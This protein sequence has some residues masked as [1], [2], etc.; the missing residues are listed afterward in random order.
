[1]QYQKRFY[2]LV[3]LLLIF[4]LSA[5]SLYAQDEPQP[6]DITL[7][8]VR[9]GVLA[10]RPKPQ[11]LAQWRPLATI[12][13]QSI[14]EYDFVIEALT[15]HEFNDALK[16]KQLDFVLTNSGHYILLKKLYGLSSPLST[17][18]VLESGQKVTSFGGVIFSKATN[19]SIKKLTD[20]KGKRIAITDNES[21]G[22]Y[23][24][25]AYELHLAGIELPKDATLHQT[26]MPHDNVVQMVLSEQS[27]VGFV[28]TGVLEK[29][30]RE[31]KINLND[32]KIINPQVHLNFPAYLSTRL[33]PE[34]PLATLP[35]IDEK[36]SRAVAAV[37]FKLDD[38]SVITK[39]MQI[40]G[41]NIPADYSVVDEMLRELRFP[42]YELAP[43]FS[44]EDIWV[45]YRS[46]I[47]TGVI[48]SVS[49]LITLLLFL[50]QYNKKLLENKWLYDTLSQHTRTVH[51][52]VTP[53]GLYTYISPNIKDL[54]GYEASELIGKVYFYNLRPKEERDS[55]KR[56]IFTFFETK[57]P[58]FNTESH[59]EAK[60]GG[61]ISV[62]AY[63]FPVFHANGSLKSYRGS[64]T[65]IT[66]QKKAMDALKESEL[67]FKTLHNA[68]FGGIVIHDKGII[69][70][71]NQGLVN[72]SGY[73][74]DELVGSNGL[75]LISPRTRTKVIEN[76][77]NSYDKPYEA[78]L[79]HKNGSLFPIRLQGKDIPYK[80]KIVRVV[81]FRDISEEKKSH[82]KLQLAASVFE[83]ARE[84]IVI[85]DARGMIMDVNDSFTHITGYERE[86]VIGQNPNILNSGRHS[87]EFYA[88]MWESISTKEHWYGEIW[89]RKK[90]GELY[91]QMLTITAIRNTADHTINHYV[92]LFSDITAIKAHEHQLQHIAHH[93]ALTNLPNRLLLADRLNQ[94]MIHAKRRNQALVVAYLD[95]D[96]FKNINDL[97]GHEIGD[98]LLIALAQQMKHTLREGDTLARMGGDEFV[99]VFQD[100][101][102]IEASI[103]ILKRLLE[104]AAMA[105]MIDDLSLHIS[106]SLGVTFYPQS[107]ELDADQ[108]LRQADQAMYQAKLAGKNRYHIFDAIEDR[109]VRSYHENLENIRH[110]L[111]ASE[112]VLYYQPKVHM[113]TGMLVGVEALIRWSHPELGILPPSAFLP[114]VE[115]HPLS[116]DIGQWVIEEAL[117]QIERW[118]T[119]GHTIA[120]SVNVGARQLQEHGFIDFMKAALRAHPSVEPSLLSLEILETS[121]LED[122]THISHLMREC[123][124]L[125]VRFSM[126]D[127]GT[128]YSS[129]TYLKQL[130]ISLLK[131]DQSFV[132]DMLENSDDLGI[133]KGILGLASAFNTEVIA[134]G[135]ETIEHGELLLMLGCEY[136][137]GYGIA[138][139]MPPEKLP[140]WLS[141]WQPHSTW[142][143]INTI[144]NEHFSLLLAMVEHRAWVKSIE[145]YI[146]NNH[147]KP[148]LPK[149]DECRFSK[150]IESKG[151][152]NY[153][154]T[155]FTKLKKLHNEIHAIAETL[156]AE[157]ENAEE[158]K[159]KEG[160]AS[161]HVKSESLRHL[162]KKLAFSKIRPS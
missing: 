97:Y 42:P 55:F 102:T 150:I 37:I 17:L 112:F 60:D 58:F 30:A 136:A 130:P 1:M 78:E 72:M 16:K 131:I 103:P 106:A 71:C 96:G 57:Q 35:H 70:D 124:L 47:I 79:I 151:L 15:Y 114:I 143:T 93:D 74:L 117:H 44:V 108:L 18:A 132:R 87:K 137:Q 107:D 41:F 3:R 75:L 152:L 88:A 111:E 118:S 52:E 48:V 53:E 36:L 23:Q 144:G 22:G 141:T 158:N 119:M 19:T 140:Q 80:G 153:T 33:Y 65:D 45:K 67:R 31:Q 104:A 9:I 32:F 64:N 63:G 6:K 5:Y 129:L 122:L 157:K 84:G 127:F 28:R 133:L 10:F 25:Q 142:L 29:M 27:D 8:M 160:L 149:A 139:P 14:P 101:A 138:H 85:T 61:I 62:L 82:E 20:I 50:L 81:E 12:L 92:A 34:W 21:L 147:P 105:V 125:G 121:A 98:K 115:Q 59:L 155:T 76:I 156:C 83:T 99:A 2:S 146:I 11:T 90:N 46:L 126:D 94:G 26:G 49:M 39:A 73:A 128:G 135:V 113:R 24:M 89:N 161:L 91:I 66:E 69:L 86:E 38:N 40:Y 109:T 134:E 145:R 54:L 162:L 51:W 68:S 7:K 148:P 56:K 110:A 159:A 120:V 4:L 95:L 123:L 13:N 43:Q 116:V 100:I 77:N 154:K